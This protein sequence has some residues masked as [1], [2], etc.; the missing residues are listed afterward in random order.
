MMRKSW[1]L[2]FLEPSPCHS[3][4]TDTDLTT[5]LSIGLRL[6]ELSR[7]DELGQV[8]F[9]VSDLFLGCKRLVRDVPVQLG[10]GLFLGQLTRLHHGIQLDLKGRVFSPLAA[11]TRGL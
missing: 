2:R 3:E 10:V 5:Q 8:P 11:A 7:G 1:G 4:A 6:G 9:Q